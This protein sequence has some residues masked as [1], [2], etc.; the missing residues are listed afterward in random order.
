MRKSHVMPP[1]SVHEMGACRP[2]EDEKV[3]SADGHVEVSVEDGRWPCCIVW[4]WLPGCTQCTAGVVGHMGIGSTGGQLWEFLGHGA[5]QGPKGGG[6]GFGPVLRY[7]PLD[8]KLVRRGTWDEG[9]EA[10]IKK[11]RG[12]MHGAVVSNCHSFVADC[13]DEM[14]YAGIPCWGYLSYLLAIW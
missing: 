12:R 13:L 2:R 9:I 1:A 8:P 7:L 10:T 6:L 11:W 4:T 14:M 5:S 3:E